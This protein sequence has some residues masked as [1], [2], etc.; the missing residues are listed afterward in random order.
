MQNEKLQTVVDIAEIGDGFRGRGAC[1]VDPVGEF[2][3][4][5]TNLTEEIVNKNPMLLPVIMEKTEMRCTLALIVLSKV[6]PPRVLQ[7]MLELHRE[8]AAI[9]EEY[10]VSLFERAC[11]IVESEE[12][13][14]HY[15]EG[16]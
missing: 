3:L 12:P 9:E 7:K 6:Y 1:V 4:A 5:E 15:L 8:I 2:M 16:F 13:I 11:E 14:L 10:G